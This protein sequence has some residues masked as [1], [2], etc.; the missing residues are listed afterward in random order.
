MCRASSCRARSAAANWRSRSTAC[1]LD[2]LNRSGPAAY[3]LQAQR[4]ASA[5]D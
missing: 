3:P 1:M 2:A 5:W 4:G